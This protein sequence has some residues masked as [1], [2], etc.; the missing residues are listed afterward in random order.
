MG[1]QEEIQQGNLKL[2]KIEEER[3]RLRKKIVLM[4]AEV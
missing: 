3:V 2:Q 1:I 4:D